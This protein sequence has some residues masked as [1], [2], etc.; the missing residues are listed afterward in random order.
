MA[1]TIEELLVKIRA[2][3]AQLQSDIAKVKGDI[4]SFKQE[5]AGIGS[6]LKTAFNVAVITQASRALFGFVAAGAQSGEALGDL[7]QTM[8]LTTEEASRL[9]YAMRVTGTNSEAG[10]K[11]IQ[12][13]ARAMAE[14]A[15]GNG[16]AAKTFDALGVSVKNGDGSIR[17]V[18]TVLLELSAR[19]EGMKNGAQK[20]QL[21]NALFSKGFGELI[22]FLNEGKESI[23]GFLAESDRVGYTLSGEA[24]EACA[25]FNTQLARL[26]AASDASAR[27]IA[28]DLSPALKELTDTLLDSDGA[29]ADFGRGLKQVGEVAFKIFTTALV[30]AL[31]QA[32]LYQNA[33]RGFGDALLALTQF[34]FK[35][36]D[37]GLR[38]MGETAQ[39]SGS[40]TWDSMVRVWTADGPKKMD[41]AADVAAGK[42]RSSLGKITKAAKDEGAQLA[43]T[44]SRMVSDYQQKLGSMGSD[45][46]TDPLKE[47]EY[48]L[49]SGDLAGKE[50]DNLD[51]HRDQVLALA[52]AYETQRTA[53]EAAA[54][55]EK[56]R[57]DLAK[58]GTEAQL[59]VQQ[60]LDEY[61]RESMQD[62]SPSEAQR[63]Q[64]EL[65]TGSLAKQLAT[66]REAGLAT[67]EYS[68]KLMQA[69]QDADAAAKQA[70]AVA[71]LRQ[72]AE[73]VAGT[74]FDSFETMLFDG[75]DKGLDQ[76]GKSF[77]RLLAD[78]LRQAAMA[79]LMQGLFGAKGD[80]GGLLGG[81]MESV[82][83]FFGGARAEGGPVSS[84]KTYLVGERGPE[85]FTPSMSGHII[86]NRELEARRE[87]RGRERPGTLTLQV[88]EG[89]RRQ[90]MA[91]YLER[92]FANAR[93]SR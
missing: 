41:K 63:M 8:G 83:N 43:E 18:G 53:A 72:V 20:A 22:P 13:L 59:E 49:S 12:K 64:V 81:A 26:K 66:M 79:N 60:A 19:F 7:A 92:E 24:S 57:A 62:G 93:A 29:M 68:A 30:G 23:G 14:A 86:P 2:D 28:A 58:R 70:E 78:M 40:E 87:R 21:A 84:S 45:G 17:A 65:T 16:E 50:N 34:D 47:L 11:G 76:M 75:F 31:G 35:G 56:D 27:T 4:G 25:Q 42:T 15:S 10:F 5:A 91:D 80:G 1:T 39:K 74:V 82:Q 69:A 3:S 44:L 32:K 90:T 52:R 67:E 48:R 88:S 46:K 37:D 36:F 73:T 71:Q 9:D 55:A 33:M 61:R 77:A 51:F 89:A 38:K 6:V 54:A 85:L